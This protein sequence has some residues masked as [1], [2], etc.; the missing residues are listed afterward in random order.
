MATHN[1]RPLL[2]FAAQGQLGISNSKSIVAGDH[3]HIFNAKGELEYFPLCD[4]FGPMN[5][6][7]V[8]RFIQMLETEIKEQTAK[9]VVYLV[10]KG[11]RAFTNGAFLLGTYLILKRDYSADRV[12]QELD[13]ENADLYEPY[14]DAT[15]S[16]AMF[17]LP[18][19][20]CWR[21]IE[22]AKTLGWLRTPDSTNA[23][24]W[25]K[26]NLVDYAHYESPLNADLTE[27][28]SISACYLLVTLYCRGRWC[29]ESL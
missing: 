24:I 13:A 12:A 2:V 9:R 16:A 4:D 17:K 10:E 5:I 20:D 7:N 1:G 23:N 28:F 19:I 25:G 22:R 15:Y 29:L 18:L 14:R 8:I 11:R 27:V 3:F 21:A 26:I 6:A